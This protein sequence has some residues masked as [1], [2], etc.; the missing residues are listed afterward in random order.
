MIAKTT[1]PQIME[2]LEATH[3][4]ILPDRR[5]HYHDTGV[6]LSLYVW[7]FAVT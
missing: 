3:T 4:P 6:F 2:L 7:T 5:H 1:N